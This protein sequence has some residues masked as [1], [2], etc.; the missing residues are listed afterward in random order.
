MKY[1]NLQ[2]YSKTSSELICFLI[3]IN[4]KQFSMMYLLFTLTGYTSI[5]SGFYV[6]EKKQYSYGLMFLGLHLCWS[7]T[8]CPCTKQIG[9]SGNFQRF[10]HV[11]VCVCVYL[12]V[13]V[14]KGRRRETEYCE[15]QFP[16][17]VIQIASYHSLLYNMIDKSCFHAHMHFTLTHIHKSSPS[18]VMQARGFILT[19]VNSSLSK[20][21]KG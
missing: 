7:R 12:F 21:N 16:T 4:N 8:P 11:C 17:V 6:H 18:Q 20:T 1:V 15:V 5:C 10:F 2:L 19:I 9:F 14:V 13:W 3:L